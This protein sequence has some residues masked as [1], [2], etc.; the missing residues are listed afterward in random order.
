[1]SER[2][3]VEYSARAMKALRK[4]DKPLAQRVLNAVNELATLDDPRVRCK[5]LSGPLIG[6]WRLRVGN[7]RVVLDIDGAHVTVIVLDAGHRSSVYD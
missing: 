2:W 1:M 7:Y 6:L 3:R 4:L 5:A